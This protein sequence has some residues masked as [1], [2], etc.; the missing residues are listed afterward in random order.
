MV[1][2]IMIEIASSANKTIDTT[3]DIL[4]AINKR[5]AIIKV[6]KYISIDWF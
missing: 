4:L 6:N 1:K 5:T 3:S 2:L